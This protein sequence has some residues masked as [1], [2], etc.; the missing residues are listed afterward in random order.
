MPTPAAPPA[1]PPLLLIDAPIYVF[2][3]WF[4][5]PDTLSDDH[6]RS[7]NAV[8]GFA[9]F[10]ADLLARNGSPYIAC[11][12]D[13][14]LTHSFRNDIDPAYKANR[15]EAP[16][17]LLRQF[18][19]CRAL[20]HALGI[21]TLA[22]SRYEAD[23][24]IGA[25]AARGRAAGH[26]VTIVSRDKDLAQLLLAPADRLWDPAADRLRGADDIEAELGVRPAQIADWLALT[27][28]AVDNIPGIPGIGPRTASQL[29]ARFGTLE[30]LLTDP[31]AVAASGLRGAARLAGRLREHAALARR[32]RRLTLIDTDAP[33]PQPPPWLPTRGPIDAAAIGALGL[34]AR[35]TERLLASAG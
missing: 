25:L 1:P 27:G 28:D 26:A 3:G 20:C 6:G 29:L 14:S 33:L 7:N 24:L 34:G 8:R 4:S 5:L 23:D 17:E 30:A 21:T 31:D 13:E 9:A 11:C 12:F 35:L 22:D 19:D 10:L 18:G 32:A 2:R 15:P 16:P